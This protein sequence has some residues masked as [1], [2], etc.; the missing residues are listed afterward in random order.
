VVGKNETRN[1]FEDVLFKTDC[2]QIGDSAANDEDGC[3]EDNE[4]CRAC[5]KTMIVMEAAGL[6]KNFPC[7][8]IRGICDYADSHKNK[9]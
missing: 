1:S 7:V 9:A 4:G 6:M 5:D 3:G 8:V 2:H